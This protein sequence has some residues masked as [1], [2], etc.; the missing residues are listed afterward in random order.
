MNDAEAKLDQNGS[1]I[2]G[3]MHEIDG[4]RA[5]AALMVVFSHFY[6][7][8]APHLSDHLYTLIHSVPYY[9][10]GTFGVD[11]FFAISGFLITSIILRHQGGENFYLWFYFRRCLRILPL[12]YFGIIFAGSLSLLFSYPVYPEDFLYY[13]SFFGNYR[14]IE[15]LIDPGALGLK[16]SLG[17]YW[18]LSV[19]EQ[20]YLF[21]PILLFWI[22]SRRALYAFVFS[23]ICLS[24]IYR[25]M[26]YESDEARLILGFSQFMTVARI[27]GLAVG[28]CTAL[29][30]QDKNSSFCR[31]LSAIILFLI[32]AIVAARTQIEGEGMLNSLRSAIVVGSATVLLGYI[33][34]SFSPLRHNRYLA[35]FFQSLAPLGF[36]LTILYLDVAGHP[37]T[38]FAAS[39][40]TAALILIMI[41]TK[42]FWN[43]FWSVRPLVY[44]GRISYG[45]YVYH[46][47][48]FWFFA[49]IIG[50]LPEVWQPEGWAF[51]NL[52]VFTVI[53]VAVLSWHLLEKPII[54]K[55]IRY[56]LK[57]PRTSKLPHED[58]SR[59]KWAGVGAA[60]GI[61]LISVAISPHL[62]STPP[63]T[64]Q[65]V[66]PNDL[67]STGLL[68][69]IQASGA[70][71]VGVPHGLYKAD[72]LLD[73]DPTTFWHSPIAD[74]RNVS[75]LTF[76]FKRPVI[77]NRVGWDA[78]EARGTWP[79]NVTVQVYE[80]NQKLWST[81]ARFT[82]QFFVSTPMPRLFSVPECTTQ[83]KGVRFIFD[84]TLVRFVILNKVFLAFT[85][86]G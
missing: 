43:T 2:S 7:F 12:A 19:E 26:I 31:H 70:F 30:I 80:E 24:V 59:L 46:V 13:A 23:S 56:A 1:A 67:Q 62:E 72:N 20:F 35:V 33:F 81:C 42:T 68:E 17:H 53:I 50:L 39:L 45:L 4:L 52:R 69:N 5:V 44:L 10:N 49:D 65:N 73:S 54:S 9:V 77:I 64:D 60:T 58:K 18:S 11:V 48:V 16:G 55:K 71:E 74:G 61:L 84:D 79:N 25:L 57:P 78:A 38:H 28:A 40:V 8:S 75:F 51:L 22:R 27:D 85:G 36:P 32:P 15:S 66:L 14:Q 29:L 86:S 37:L 63:L 83:A 3:R 82:G 34:V 41:Q 47:I 21:W 76:N 6:V